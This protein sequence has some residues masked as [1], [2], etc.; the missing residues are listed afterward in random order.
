MKV[1]MLFTNQQPNTTDMVSALEEQFLLV[2]HARDRGWDS[3]FAGQHYLNEGGNKMLQQVP[4]LARLAAEAGEMKLGM[5]IMVLGVHN[6]VYVAETVSSLD[7]IA[8][9]NLIFGVG[10]GYRN[11]E[12]EAF[13]VWRGQRVKRF[14]EC[15]TLVKQLWSGEAVSFESDYCKLDNAQLALLPV[16]QPHPPIWFAAHREPAIRRAARMGDTWYI[17]PNS[18][19]R[20]IAQQLVDYRDELAKHDKPFPAELPCRKEIFCAKDK[21][22]AME[23]AAPYMGAKYRIYAEWFKKGK[24]KLEKAYDKPFE[25]LLKDRFIIGSPEDCYEQLRPYWEDLGVTHFV[26]RT[27]FVGMPVSYALHSMRTISEELLPALHRAQ[28]K[29]HERPV[30]AAG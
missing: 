3:V 25:E 28:P 22:T 27:H 5:G 16:Q 4:F 15:L 11:L 18:T 13:G 2:R 29:R 6:P 19:P 21:A 30:R 26:F 17:N 20:R 8:R 14:E 23:M 9:G 7:V 1:G 12:F 10:L 24:K